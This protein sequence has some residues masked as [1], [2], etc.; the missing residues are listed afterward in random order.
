ML[1]FLFFEVT[2]T[3]DTLTPVTQL[4]SGSLND[5]S[6]DATRVCTVVVVVA[7]VVVV[8]VVHDVVVVAV[9]VQVVVV[10]IFVL[11]SE[12]DPAFAGW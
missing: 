10:D 12:I 8:V 2:I 5:T 4:A 11:K 3:A 7:L 1:S 6:A 9:V